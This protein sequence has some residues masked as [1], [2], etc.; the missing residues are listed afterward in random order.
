MLPR[1][2]NRHI[3]MNLAVVHA[4][5]SKL[6]QGGDETVAEYL[7]KFLN[8]LDAKHWRETVANVTLASI[9]DDQ[10]DENDDAIEQHQQDHIQQQEEDHIQQP[11][12]YYQSTFVS[13][14]NLKERPQDLDTVLHALKRERGDR[15]QKTKKPSERLVVEN[16][17]QACTRFIRLFRQGYFGSYYLD[18]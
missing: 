5:N 16:R 17:R 18:E 7:L 15:K 12:H 9:T 13:A 14:L 4:V 11:S 2:T 3:G 6:I 10:N 8:Y 1:L